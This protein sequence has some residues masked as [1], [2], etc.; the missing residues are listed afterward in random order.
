LEPKTDYLFLVYLPK[1]KDTFQISK[2]ITFSTLSKLPARQ[3]SNIAFDEITDSSF[4]VSWV[5]GS[6]EGRIVV[7][8]K[9]EKLDLPENA[10]EYPSSSVYGKGGN[11]GGSSYVV[12]DGSDLRPKVKVTGLEPGTKYAVGVFEYNGDGKYRHYN[13][14]SESN[15]PRVRATR[16][17]APRIIE[18]SR[19]EDGVYRIKWEKSKGGVTYILDIARDKEFKEFV[20]PYKELDIGDLESYE[21][22][23]LESKSKYYVRLK[24]KGEWGESLYSPVF[25]LKTK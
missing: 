11:I 17:P 24:A 3:S 22:T 6:G 7:V 20:E 14:K 10:K 19:V 16:I 15:N 21:I 4:V 12:Y 23:E 1:V 13:T 25:E 2:K 5:N 18:A 8:S 9:G